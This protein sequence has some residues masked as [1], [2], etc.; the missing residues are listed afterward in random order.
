MTSNHSKRIHFIGLLTLFLPFSAQ[1]T[2]AV[3]TQAAAIEQ[4]SQVWEQARSL[5]S[6]RPDWAHKVDSTEP[7][8]SRSGTLVFAPSQISDPQAATLLI[9]RSGQNSDADFRRA[10]AEALPDTKSPELGALI[11]AELALETS[12]MVRESLAHSLR[13]AQDAATQSALERAVKDEDPKV[14]ETALASIR[15][16][17]KLE[18]FT[19]VIVAALKDPE[20]QVQAAALRAW[21]TLRRPDLGVKIEPW[22]RS[23]SPNVRLAALRGQWRVDRNVARQL[24][25]ALGLDEDPEPK[26]A[27]LAQRILSRA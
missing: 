15:A 7:S 1:A 20:P 17:A 19:A 6:E 10:V 25:E 18:F 26:I 24:V 9:A 8:R 4:Q 27:R 21:G 2:P 23:E 14:R 16:H 5:R 12:A 22:L 13:Y 11:A 3:L